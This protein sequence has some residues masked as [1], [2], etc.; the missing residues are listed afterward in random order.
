[1]SRPR[2]R[3]RRRAV[4]DQRRVLV[5]RAAGRD[6]PEPIGI[7]DLFLVDALLAVVDGPA[8]APAGGRGVGRGRSRCGGPVG[9]RDFFGTAGG[10]FRLDVGGRA[11][12]HRAGGD[13]GDSEDL[14]L[15]GAVQRR[16]ADLERLA[17]LEA[18]GDE[19]A[20]VGAG[21]R[22]GATAG[23]GE[24]H[25]RRGGVLDR[26]VGR[27]AGVGLAQDANS[28]DILIFA[29]CRGAGCVLG[30]IVDDQLTLAGGRGVEVLMLR[31]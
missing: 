7:D 15:R 10:A 16:A 22:S 23:G 17:D 29:E 8:V 5:E 20:A 25:V 11:H 2:G 30:Q 14:L 4:G 19:V 24:I 21:D 28:R 9:E 13:G 3:D 1:M 26:G 27:P 18:G 31:S 6:Q 12:G